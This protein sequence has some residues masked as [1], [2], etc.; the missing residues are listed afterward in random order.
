MATGGLRGQGHSHHLMEQRPSVPILHILKLHAH[1]AP[2]EYEL[3]ARRPRTDGGLQHFHNPQ[4]GP[5]KREPAQL[6]ESFLG[7]DP[8]LSLFLEESL[9]SFACEISVEFGTQRRYF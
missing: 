9:G 2:L 3:D 5:R 6:L 4:P 1:S 7:R 8:K